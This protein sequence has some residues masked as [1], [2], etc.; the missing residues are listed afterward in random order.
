MSQD[1]LQ[2]LHKLSQDPE[3]SLTKIAERL[4]SG[5]ADPLL[6]QAVAQMID[7][8]AKVHPFSVRLEARHIRAGAPRRPLHLELGRFIVDRIEAGEKLEAVMQDAKEKF[9]VSRS[10]AFNA[11]EAIR[12]SRDL[13]QIYRDLIAKDQESK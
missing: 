3:G 2:L 5:R 7:P 11:L 12:H 1:T 8:N 13:A 10:T 6:L 9:G 4:R